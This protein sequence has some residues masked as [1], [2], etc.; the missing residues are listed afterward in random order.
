[1]S[2]FTDQL[3]KDLA[4]FFNTD[5]FAIDVLYND[6]AGPSAVPAVVD[7]AAPGSGTKADHALITVKKSEV[8]SPGYRH[9]FTIDSVVWTISS[10]PDKG[11]DIPGDDLTWTIPI[12]KSE[13]FSQWRK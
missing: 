1:M 6:G 10:D 8:P 13:R 5:E 7:Y 2:N 3:A 4:V 9:T 12:S 11:L